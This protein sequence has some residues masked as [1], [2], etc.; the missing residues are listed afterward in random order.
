VRIAELTTRADDFLRQYD[1]EP[2]LLLP[3]GESTREW[4]VSQVALGKNPQ[5]VIAQVR[6]M[7]RD[8]N[9]TEAQA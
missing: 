2:D 4:F 3:I 8:M 1:L 6:S 9:E 5:E 7:R